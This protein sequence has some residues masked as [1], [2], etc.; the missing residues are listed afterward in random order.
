MHVRPCTSQAFAISLAAFP[1]QSFAL[2]ETGQAPFDIR[3]IV[4]GQYTGTQVGWLNLHILRKGRRIK[5]RKEP[6]A[7]P[8]NCCILYAPRVYHQ[9]K[10]A[11]ML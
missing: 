6:L 9:D 5:K 3:D 11:C 8:L 7:L 4:E 1:A 10:S 2:Q